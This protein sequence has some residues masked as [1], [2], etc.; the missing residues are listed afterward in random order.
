MSLNVSIKGE[1]DAGESVIQ[2]GGNKVKKNKIRIL[3][4]VRIEEELLK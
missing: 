1:N 4:Q 3:H 2:T